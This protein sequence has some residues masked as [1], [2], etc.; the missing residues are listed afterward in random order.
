[1]RKI[2][3]AAR[4]EDRELTQEERD[5][6]D[7]IEKDEENL[8]DTIRREETVTE[9][10]KEISETMTEHAEREQVS[11]APFKVEERKLNITDSPEYREMFAEYCRTGYRSAEFRHFQAELD[12]QAGY[13]VT[14]QTIADG[15][16]EKARDELFVRKYARIFTVPSAE[17][18]GIITLETLPAVPPAK[19]EIEQAT[20]ETTTAIGKRELRPHR[21]ANFIRVSNQLLRQSFVDM[22]SWITDLFSYRYNYELENDYLNGTGNQ[23]SLGVFTSSSEG[24]GSSARDYSTGNSTSA[25]VSDNL[26]GNVYNLKPQYRRRA[27]WLLNRTGIRKFRQLVDGEGRY[28][29]RDGLIAGQPDT[30]CGYPVDESELVPD[31][32]STG[33]YVGIFCDW[34]QYVIADSLKFEMKRLEEIRAEYGQTVFLG[35]I[36]TDGMPVHEEAFSRIT[37]G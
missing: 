23:E 33:C 36:Y 13:A 30:L 22:A 31:T 32:W 15:I 7:R 6:Y 8:R 14:P 19:G 2:L 35:E 25:V 29:W 5:T 20:A 12:A 10:E 11:E 16:W 37:L 27:R 9:L 17:S 24:I 28:H 26:L 21:K 1:M 18:L 3:D 34:S 4:E